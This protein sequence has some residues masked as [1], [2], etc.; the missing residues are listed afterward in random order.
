MFGSTISKVEVQQEQAGSLG[1]IIFI[2]AAGG[3]QFT[4]YGTQRMP[5]AGGQSNLINGSFNLN[6][7]VQ[8]G[9]ALKVKV[10]SA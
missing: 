2:D 5:T 7:P 8:K 1:S 10:T 3:T 9:W 6:M 4:G